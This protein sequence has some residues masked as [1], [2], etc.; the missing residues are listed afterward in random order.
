V[1]TRVVVWRPLDDRHALL[2]TL[3]PRTG[4]VTVFGRSGA[5]FGQ[6]ECAVEGDRIA[7][8][9]VGALSVWRLP[10]DPAT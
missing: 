9:V 6:P 10:P 2:G 4:N 3:D 1:N 5:W 8:V 7:C